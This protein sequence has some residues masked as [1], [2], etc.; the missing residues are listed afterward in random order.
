MYFMMPIAAGM[1]TGPGP[2]AM[3]LGKYTLCPSICYETVIPHVIRRHVAELTAQGNTPDVLVNITNDAWFWGSSELDMHLACTIMRC[4]ETRTPVVIAA[5]G[6]LSAVIDGSGRVRA[7]QSHDRASA[8][9]NRAARSARQL[10]CAPRRLAGRKLCGA[11][12]G[13]RTLRV[14]PTLS[15]ARSMSP[16]R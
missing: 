3:P 15:R 10:L 7:E 8:H 12:G 14:S 1:G 16:R 5:N 11:G 2:V 9:R 4:V 13:L 6:G